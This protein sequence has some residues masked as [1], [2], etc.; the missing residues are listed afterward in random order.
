MGRHGCPA[1]LVPLWCVCVRVSRGWLV[2]TPSCVAVC[3]DVF[4][5]VFMFGGEHEPRVP[6]DD[7]LLSVDTTQPDA[8]WTPVT[9]VRQDTTLSLSSPPCG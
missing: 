5:Q 8:S 9:L 3:T 1:M 7:V 2:L 4:Q 6:V